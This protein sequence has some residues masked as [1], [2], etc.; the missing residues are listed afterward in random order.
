MSTPWQPLAYPPGPPPYP[1]AQTAGSTPPGTPTTAHRSGVRRAGT[2]AAVA[3]VA[4]VAGLAG[5]IVGAQIASAPT[6]SPPAA[7]PSSGSPPAAPDPTQVRTQ[8]IDLCTRFAAGYAA[9]PSPQKS[10]ADVV[11]ATNYI[12]DALRDNPIA[13]P[14]VRAAVT[15]SLRLFRSQ[16][17]ALSREPSK[18]AVQPPADWTAAASN[19][20]DDAVWSA[21]NGY[22]G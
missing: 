22:L 15:E 18:G 1:P 2:A 20:A 11:P 3:A 13:D 16:A 7:G 4:F 10:A 21:C 6:T 12:S 5:V 14:G 8:T 9:V 19:A 17:A